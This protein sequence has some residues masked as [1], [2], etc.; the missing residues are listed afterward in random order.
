MSNR[1][2]L[3]AFM[4][5]LRAMSGES[6][7]IEHMESEGQQRAVNNTMVAKEMLPSRKDWEQLGFTFSDIPGDD[8]LCKATLPE[9]WRIK[10]TDHS[11]WNDII[12]QNGRKRGSMFYKSSFYDRSAH[13]NLNCRYGVRLDYIG[14]DYATTEIYFGNDSEKLFVA[15]QVCTPKNAT[16]EERLARYAEEDRLKAIAKKFGDE[17]YPNWQSV[18]AY[19]NDE[20]E[21]SHGTTRTRKIND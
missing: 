9:G 6:N 19:W 1:D 17:N 2:E 20:K 15:G 13:M 7:V 14:E 3:D 18:H 10:A 5:L 8:V 4:M 21:L 16:R 11:M 12:D